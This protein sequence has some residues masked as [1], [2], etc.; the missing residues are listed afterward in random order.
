V[1]EDPTSE[2]AESLWSKRDGYESAAEGVRS[3]FLKYQWFRLVKSWLNSVYLFKRAVDTNA[4]SIERVSGVETVCHDR[5]GL[6]EEF[7]YVYVCMFMKLH[8]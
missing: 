3:C 1:R 4:V 8:V 7:Y 2:H 6:E 5:E